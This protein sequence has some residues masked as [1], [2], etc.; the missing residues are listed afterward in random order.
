MEIQLNQ[1]GPF[2]RNCFLSAA[3][4]GK[5]EI[6]KYLNFQNSNLKTSKDWHNNT[7]LSLALL[8]TKWNT[9]QFLLTELKLDEIGSQRLRARS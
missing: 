8:G 3:A 6:M 2:G 1:T 4:G 5:I 7:A 9:I